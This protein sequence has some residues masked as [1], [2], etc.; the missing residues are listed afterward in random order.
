MVQFQLKT[1]FHRM[2]YTMYIFAFLCSTYQF[3]L[4]TCFFVWL[5]SWYGLLLSTGFVA[6][7]HWRPKLALAFLKA[8]TKETLIESFIENAVV[9][10]IVSYKK[11]NKYSGYFFVKS[12]S[13]SFSW[14]WFHEKFHGKKLYFGKYHF[15]PFY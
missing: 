8:A 1:K 10:H 3:L 9:R 7:L 5:Y 12:I 6:F 2:Q 11:E 14:N 4:S 13:R 15:P